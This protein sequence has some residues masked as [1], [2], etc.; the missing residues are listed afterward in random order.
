M[1]DQELIDQTVDAFRRL[2]EN[3]YRVPDGFN[4]EISAVYG[5][6]CW[7]PY[8]NTGMLI[9][10]LR[11]DPDKHYRLAPVPEPLPWR[12]LN[13]KSF[14]ITESEVISLAPHALANLINQ[15]RVENGFSDDHPTYQRRSGMRVVY[16]QLEGK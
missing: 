15:R 10:F 12:K 3:R 8:G 13:E 6:L 4:L 16:F 9:Q 14:V 2:F 5:K 11:L 7:F 1:T